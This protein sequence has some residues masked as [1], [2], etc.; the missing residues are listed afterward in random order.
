MKVLDGHLA[1]QNYLLG[2][3]FSAADLNLS[4]IFTLGQV[5][6]YDMAEYPNVASWADSCLGRP[7]Y[8][9]IR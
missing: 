4:S 9:R 3:D 7:A 8:K 2:G 1:Q 6:R 5:A